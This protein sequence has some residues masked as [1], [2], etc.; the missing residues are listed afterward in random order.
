VNRIIMVSAAVLFPA[1][2]LTFAIFRRL[3]KH[4]AHDLSGAE[5]VLQSS[6]LD[7]TVVRPPRLTN[8]SHERYRISENALPRNGFSASF[9]AVAVF[10]LDAAE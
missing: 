10:M 9:R 4:I 1:R 7:W 6:A 5:A 8:G 3:L 2:G